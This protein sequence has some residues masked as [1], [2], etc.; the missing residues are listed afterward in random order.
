MFFGI[1]LTAFRLQSCG[2]AVRAYTISFN[3][4]MI[5]RSKLLSESAGDSAFDVMQRFNI[6]S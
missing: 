4:V 5:S 1:M 6:Q 3:E 2:R